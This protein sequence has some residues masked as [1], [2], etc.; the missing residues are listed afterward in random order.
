MVRIEHLKEF[1]E[2]KK[3]K[4]DYPI[5]VFFPYL[6]WERALLSLLFV[7]VLALVLLL[8]V[9]LRA[10]KCVLIAMVLFFKT[11]EVIRRSNDPNQLNLHS[12]TRYDVNENLGSLSDEKKERRISHLIAI[13]WKKL[14]PIEQT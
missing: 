7:F 1:P 9:L 10:T 14:Y 5:L 13:E 4:I 3:I 8:L 6:C 11:D 12:S 2:I